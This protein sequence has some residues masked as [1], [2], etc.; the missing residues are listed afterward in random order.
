[1]GE[2]INDIQDNLNL[3]NLNLLALRSSKYPQVIHARRLRAVTPNAL[4]EEGSK[5]ATWEGSSGKHSSLLPAERY[6]Y[7]QQAAHL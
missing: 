6:R 3:K 5:R 7:L 2:R 1:M 4:V